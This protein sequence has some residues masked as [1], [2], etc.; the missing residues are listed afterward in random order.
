MTSSFNLHGVVALAIE[1]G[2]PA[3]HRYFENEYRRSSIVGGAQ[4]A[5]A[6]TVRLVDRLPEPLAGDR[7]RRVRFKRLFTFRFLVRGYESDRVTLFFERHPVDRI[8]VVAVGV[9]LQAQ[10]LEPLLYGK[11]LEADVLLLHAAGVA[12]EGAATLFPAHGGTGKTTLSLRLA[13]QGYSLLGDDLIVVDVREGVARSHRRPLHLFSYNLRQFRAAQ[14]P[15]WLGAI[16]RFKDVLRFI[17]ETVLRVEFLISTRAHADRLLPDLRWATSPVPVRQIFFLSA[18][19][20]P[21]WFPS[22]DPAAVHAAAALIAGSGDLIASLNA[23]VLTESERRVVAEREHALLCRLMRLL[24][25]VQVINPRALS[26]T[27]LER[28]IADGL[29]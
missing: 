23:H 26:D 15:W 27:D 22:D 25:G 29:R 16:I 20:S 21:R 19:V 3:Y 28:T 14:F 9:F 7:M 11:L 8:Y 18:T 12:A 10:V 13:Q 6:V 2:S 24:P 5:L 4:P 1:G 17:L